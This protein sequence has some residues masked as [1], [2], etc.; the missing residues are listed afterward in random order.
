MVDGG[1]GM[2]LNPLGLASGMVMAARGQE[3]AAPAP[4]VGAVLPPAVATARDSV[5]SWKVSGVVPVLCCQ[6][7][8]Q[9][10]FLLLTQ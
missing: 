6:R 1:I 8:L 5:S 7:I 10:P 2:G 3:V 4:I 9:Y